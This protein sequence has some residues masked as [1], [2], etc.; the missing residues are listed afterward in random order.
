MDGHP[1]LPEKKVDG[2]S[3]HE[4]LMPKFREAEQYAIG[5]PWLLTVF[6]TPSPANHH[7]Q[8]RLNI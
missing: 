2:R 4:R 5:E 1:P 6:C 3:E 8:N 7:S